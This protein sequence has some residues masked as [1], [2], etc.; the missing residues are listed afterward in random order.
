MSPLPRAFRRD[1]ARIAAVAGILT[2]LPPEGPEVTLRSKRLA[3]ELRQLL[4]RWGKDPVCLAEG[5]ALAL[6]QSQLASLESHLEKFYYASLLELLEKWRH[7]LIQ[8]TLLQGEVIVHE[9]VKNMPSEALAEELKDIV[10]HGAPET[11]DP[12]QMYRSGESS[13]D[14]AA[15]AYRVELAEFKASWPERVNAALLTRLENLTI[16]DVNAWEAELRATQ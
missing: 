3:R 4:A 8:E 13:A 11:Y 2:E 12:E 10:T 9:L 16:E 7:R 14:V 1:A 5:K 15:E 6:F